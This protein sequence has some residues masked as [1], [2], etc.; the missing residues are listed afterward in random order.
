MNSRRIG[1]TLGSL[2]FLICLGWSASHVHAQQVVLF[3]FFPYDGVNLPFD[4]SKIAYGSTQ[5]EV[6]AKRT[7]S[8]LLGGF[9]SNPQGPV[10]FFGILPD[11]SCGFKWLNLVN[12]PPG[13]EVPVADFFAQGAS[14]EQIRFSIGPD[15]PLPPICFLVEDIKRLGEKAVVRSLRK[16][17]KQWTSLMSSIS[18]GEQAWINVGLLLLLSATGA[19]KSDLR[20]AF[21]DALIAGPVITIRSI[22]SRSP[23]LR[24][25][26]GP[27]AHL[28]YH[29]AENSIDERLSAVA[30]VLVQENPRLTDASLRTRLNRC[31]DML[32]QADERLR[33]DQSNRATL[34]DQ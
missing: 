20:I 14:C 16:D 32:Q 7:G 8:E 6:C 23:N 13:V 28:E 22:S 10:T 1:K 27:S 29:L 12:G 33:R 4:P 31:A 9:Q 2:F 30:S 3:T 34:K 19:A 15:A 26:C 25:I 21:E 24:V 11:G 18:S 17:K 5:E